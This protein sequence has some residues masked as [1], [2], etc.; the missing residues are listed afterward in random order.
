MTLMDQSDI[1]TVR[2]FHRHGVRPSGVFLNA[3]GSYNR[4]GRLPLTR[5]FPSLCWSAG[6]PQPG[7]DTVYQYVYSPEID[8][9]SEQFDTEDDPHFTGEPTTMVDL[10]NACMKD[11]M[12][13]DARIPC[14]ARTS[15]TSA[16]SS[17]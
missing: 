10:L 3:E 16:A 14:S 9:T 17:T 6:T 7:T 1:H 15:P 8:P 11:E 5:Q 2:V 4:H 12:V 13:R